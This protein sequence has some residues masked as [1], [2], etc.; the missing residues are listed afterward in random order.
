MSPG[1][2][3][4]ALT[5]ADTGAELAEDVLLCGDRKSDKAQVA[6]LIEEILGLRAVNAG[7]LEMARIV[8]QLTPP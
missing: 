1:C 3:I 2:T 8:E 5:L 7:L 6:A 4:S